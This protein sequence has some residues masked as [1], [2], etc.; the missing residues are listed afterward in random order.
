MNRVGKPAGGTQLLLDITKPLLSDTF[1]SAASFPGDRPRAYRG[2]HR[3]P[4]RPP[5]RSQGNVIVGRLIPAGY[6][7]PIVLTVDDVRYVIE[8]VDERSLLVMKIL[9]RALM[10]RCR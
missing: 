7:M 2:Q 6:G 9:A 10:R 4:G 1:I 3:R 5:A 8:R